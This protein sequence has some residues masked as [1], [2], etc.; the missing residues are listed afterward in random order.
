MPNVYVLYF[1]S[2]RVVL[3]SSTKHKQFSKQPL[4]AIFYLLPISGERFFLWV[5]IRILIYQRVI[6]IRNADLILMLSEVLEYP[7]NK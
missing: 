4:A 6:K 1:C 2:R 3:Q 5:F 7:Y